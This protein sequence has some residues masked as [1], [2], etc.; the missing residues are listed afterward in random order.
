[1]E[2]AEEQ[3]HYASVLLSLREYEAFVM[4]ELHRRKQH[5]QRLPADQQ[6][7]LPP[8]STLRSLHRFV[9]RSLAAFPAF[10]A[11]AALP[12]ALTKDPAAAY[13]RRTRRIATRRSWSASCR[14]SSSP[15]RPCSCPR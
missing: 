8:S 11:S 3:A 12:Q 15:A 2:D 1:M 7:R 14:R 13:A 10:P 6:R 4:R 9:V 5:L